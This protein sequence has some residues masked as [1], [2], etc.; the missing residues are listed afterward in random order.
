[1]CVVESS[2]P[3][4]SKQDTDVLSVQVSANLGAIKRIYP[5][6]SGMLVGELQ[7]ILVFDSL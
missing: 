1:M 4:V 5:K 2:H 3:T 7:S 6:V